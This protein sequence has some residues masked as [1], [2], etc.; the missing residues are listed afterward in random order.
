MILSLIYLHI[1]GAFLSLTLLFIRGIM[2][3][4]NQDWRAVKLLKILPHLSDTLLIAS[5]LIIVF[6]T[7]YGFPLW[8]LLKIVLLAVYI[9]FARKFFSKKSVEPKKLHLNLAGGALLAAILIG[10][11]H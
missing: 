5:G 3:L 9:V 11:F 6:Y 10:Y 1:F 2:Q 4:N 8:I 7:G